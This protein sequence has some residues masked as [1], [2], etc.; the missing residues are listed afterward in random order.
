MCLGGIFDYVEK[1]DRLAE[2]ELELA[3]PDVWNDP[4]RAQSLGKDRASLEL[5]VETIDSLD[6][7]VAENSELL[8]MAAEEDDTDTLADVESEVA[9]L[10]ARLE[11]LEFRRMFS[12]AMDSNSAYLDIQAGSGGTEAQDWAEMLLRMY[13]RWGEQK[14]FKVELIEE[15]G[16]A[17]V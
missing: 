7:G 13:L 16:R 1:K 4:A 8:E 5:V 14:G 17:H 11:I 9:C 2:V 15:I 10:T 3:D 12:G 6:N